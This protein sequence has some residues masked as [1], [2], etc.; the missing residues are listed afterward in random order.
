VLLSL[1]LAGGMARLWEEQRRTQ[2]ALDTAQESRLRERQAL[3]FTFTASDQVAAR[4][5][6]RIASPGTAQAP[7]E[8]QCDQE[9]CRKALGY[10]QEIAGRYRDD[11]AMPAIVAAAD[12]RIGFIRMILKEPSAEEAYHRSIALYQR[13][14]AAAPDDPDLRRKLALAYYD[15]ILLLRTTG[16]SAAALDCFPHLLALRRGLSVDFP[17]ETDNLVSLA[18]HRAEYCGLLEDAGRSAE[19]GEVGR[20][21]RD[22]SLPTLRRVPGHARS[23]NNMAWQLSWRPESSSQD[24]IL[25]VELAEEAIALAPSTASAASRGAYWNTLGVAHY[26]AGHWKPAIAALEK[27]MQLRS[28]GDAHDWLFLAMARR[29]LGDPVEARRW[30]DRSLAWIEAH[31]PRHEELIRIRAEAANFW[32]PGGRRPRSD[33]S[34]FD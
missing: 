25:A 26:R 9:F 16:Q 34:A 32:E 2:A 13:L 29:R 7:A 17:D 18:Y 15:L 23:C 6:A 4:A 28:G 24:A 22:N 27:S 12:H 33:P 19:A 10:Y 11:P 20:E 8:V 1:A 30:Y 14:L 3:I 5:L 31:A 21:F